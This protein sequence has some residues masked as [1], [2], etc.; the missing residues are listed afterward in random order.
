MNT[1][2]RI[3]VSL[4]RHPKAIKLRR[5]LGADGVIALI[6]L[7]CWAA[8]YRPNG[9]LHDMTEEDIELA[10]QWPNESLTDRSTFVTTL[11]E[12]RWVNLDNGVYSLHD[13]VDHNG[14][15]SCANDRSDKSR[16]SRMAKTHPAIYKELK[17][18][19]VTAISA[20]DFRKVTTVKRPLNDSLNTSLTE[21]ISPLPSPSPSPS[22]KDI[23]AQ[24]DDQAT[25]LQV[26]KLRAL[27]LEVCGMA[28]MPPMDRFREWLA[29]GKTYREIETAYLKVS[30]YPMPSR[31]RLVIDFVEDP[32]DK[33]TGSG[34]RKTDGKTEP[35]GN[36]E[37]PKD[38]AGDMPAVGVG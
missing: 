32:H 14:Y 29:A 33:R 34:K 9:V 19:G 10:A 37:G 25:D 5:R 36:T 27:H 24:E 28:S 13:W 15:A 7:W 30:G 2:I 22:P 16:F 20:E 31:A 12:L 11:L 38:W 35:A 18:K 1:D 8:Q 23:H 21:R 6:E 17:A 4:F 3:N 26:E